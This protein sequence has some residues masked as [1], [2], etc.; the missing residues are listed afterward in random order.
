VISRRSFRWKTRTMVL[1]PTR[2]ETATKEKVARRTIPCAVEKPAA[3]I[4]WMSSQASPV[5]LA[6]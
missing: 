6:P 3:E 1:G 2:A 5:D 4:G